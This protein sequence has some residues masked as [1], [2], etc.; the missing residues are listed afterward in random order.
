MKNENIKVIPVNQNEVP[1]R[2]RSP[3]GSSTPRVEKPKRKSSKTKTV[4]ARKVIAIII[5][6]VWCTV[7]SR[8]CF[9]NAERN[10]ECIALSTRHLFQNDFA[11]TSTAINDTISILFPPYAI[12]LLYLISFS[13]FILSIGQKVKVDLRTF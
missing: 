4:V 9:S 12:I 5:F 11:N 13:I 7:K 6:L 3:G 1:S 2:R 10:Q 8:S